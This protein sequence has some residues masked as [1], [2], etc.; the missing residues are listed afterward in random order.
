MK[1]KVWIIIVILLLIIIAAGVIAYFTMFQEEPPYFYY[2][3]PGE[4]FITNITGSSSLVKITAVIE[5]NQEKQEKFL[6]EQMAVIRDAIIGV[7]RS[8]TEEEMRA[9]DI[10]TILSDQI[11][12]VLN[13]QFEVTFFKRIYFSDFVVQ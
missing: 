1:N 13:T 11:C 4:E 10:Q 7:L 8:K 3:T 5:I 2:F 6:A 12:E 9:A